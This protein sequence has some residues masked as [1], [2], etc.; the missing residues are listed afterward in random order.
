V[1]HL[2]GREPDPSQDLDGLHLGQ[3]LGKLHA[4]A[5]REVL[6]DGVEGVQGVLLMHNPDVLGRPPPSL[7][8]KVGHVDPVIADPHQHLSMGGG[9]DAGDHP[10][11][12]GLPG[13]ALPD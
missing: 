7:L 3:F 6:Q 12:G 11:E 10:G 2:L 8:S 4:Q 1:I 5:D 13:P 9:S